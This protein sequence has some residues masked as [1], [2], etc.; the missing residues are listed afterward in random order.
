MFNFVPV[1]VLVIAIQRFNQICVLE[2]KPNTTTIWIHFML[3]LFAVPSY[4]LGNPLNQN[5]SIVMTI[6]IIAFQLLVLQQIFI[7]IIFYRNVSYIVKLSQQITT[8]HPRNLIRSNTAPSRFT[9]SSVVRQ[10]KSHFQY[11]PCHE[12]RSSIVAAMT[13]FPFQIS[14][15]KMPLA[16]LRKTNRHHR[17][18]Q[19]MKKLWRH[20]MTRCSFQ[21]QASTTHR[22]SLKCRWKPQILLILPRSK[23]RRHK[24][25][26][27]FSMYCRQE[28]SRSPL[29]C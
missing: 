28:E 5:A 21:T 4:C 8:K 11:R 16:N 12:A 10:T 7:C 14:S 2:S 9:T 22:N 20:L 23:Q 3:S 18:L 24:S 27:F 15:G 25:E 29:T 17:C 1:C 19:V 13:H 26:K 6:Q